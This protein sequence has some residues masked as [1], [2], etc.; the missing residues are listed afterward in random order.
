ML[1]NSKSHHVSEEILNDFQTMANRLVS[2]LALLDL[3]AAFDTLGYRL[4]RVIIG[5][6]RLILIIFIRQISLLLN[7]ACF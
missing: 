4:E 6:T 2:T 7:D 3:S 5:L 1:V